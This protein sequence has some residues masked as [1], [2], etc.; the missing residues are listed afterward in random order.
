MSSCDCNNASISYQYKNS[1]TA[2]ICES[3][4]VSDA[5]EN[6]NVV[7]KIILS[8]NWLDVDGCGRT[9]ARCQTVSISIDDL[10]LIIRNKLAEL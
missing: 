8:R 2:N 3:M 7:D 4:P 5:F 10:A 1:A 9:S 6:T